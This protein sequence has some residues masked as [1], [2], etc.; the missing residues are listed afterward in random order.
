MYPNCCELLQVVCLLSHVQLFA[1]PWTVALQAPLSM[2]I[3]QAR[4]PECVK[5]EV[6]Q[7]CPTLCDPIDYCVGEGDGTPLQC[8]CL[9]N[10]I[11]GGAW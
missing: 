9:E 5:S 1:T 3:L 11:D 6:A 8:S 10:P 4:I 2:G 7:S